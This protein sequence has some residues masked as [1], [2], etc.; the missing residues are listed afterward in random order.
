[1]SQLRRDPP[2]RAR[3]PWLTITLWA[4]AGYILVTL[5]LAWLQK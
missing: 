4:V 2:K 3:L 5:I 1:M